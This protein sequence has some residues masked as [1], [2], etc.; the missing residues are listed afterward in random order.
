VPLP[1]LAYL[2]LGLAVGVLGT[3]VGAGG[4]FVL[5]PVLLFLNPNDSP[6]LLTSISLA[7]VLANAL[8]GSIAYGFRR[9]IDY[10]SGVVFAL[11]TIPGSVAGAFLTESVPRRTFDGL[12]GGLMVAAAAFL[13]LRPR[14]EEAPSGRRPRF[15][16]SRALVDAD[17]RRHR[18]RYN[19][20]LAVALS[21]V[22]GFVSSF[23]GIGGGILHVPALI[24][25][26][27]FPLHVATATSH[28]VLSVMAAAGTTV[29]VAN[30]AFAHGGVRRTLLLSAGAVA[31]AQIG[32]WLSGRV[33]SR[34]ILRLLAAALGLAGARILWTAL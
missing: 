3:L 27:D 2:P 15:A 21:A 9:R 20:V 5:M 29:H 8:S 26:L 25:L 10:R 11:A 6:E 28:F 23:L 22:V 30:G 16:W 17:G 19:V 18:Y 13:V 4:G 14:V 32:A 34:T 7:V 24:Y 1:L 31:G 33:H 12:F